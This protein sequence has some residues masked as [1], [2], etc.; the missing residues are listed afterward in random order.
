MEKSGKAKTNAHT[1]ALYTDF[2]LTWQCLSNPIG[3][4]LFA[5]KNTSWNAPVA[6]EI[7]E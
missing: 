2:N 1:S 6:I 5:E 3:E 4:D 7:G